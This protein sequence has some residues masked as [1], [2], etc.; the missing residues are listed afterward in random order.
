[1]TS[2]LSSLTA[3]ATLLFAFLFACAL[4][5]EDAKP[6]E[7]TL[8]G[9]VLSNVHTG[10]KQKRVFI[11]AHGGTPEIKAEYDK[12]LEAFYPE[13]GLDADAARKLQDEFL[14]RV[15]YDVDG[16]LVDAMYKEAE[17]TVRGPKAVTGVLSVRDGRKWITARNWEAAT[18]DIPAK[19]RAVDQPFVLPNQ[20][21][22]AL[23]INDALTLKC[24]CIPAGKFMMGEPF[25]QI[26][27]WQED[28]PHIVT[29]SKPYYLAECP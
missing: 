24:I 9:N 12:I 29:I 25:Y 20:E 3:S 22:L 10:E 4:R 1:M 28:P 21:P 18:Y 27:H 15:T 6:V 19:M 23:K 7:V 8:A 13:K 2:R 11:L 17:W 14:A 26:P 5:A 16:P